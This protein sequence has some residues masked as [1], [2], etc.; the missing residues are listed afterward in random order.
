MGYSPRDLIELDMT[1]QLLTHS[2]KLPGLLLPEHL[3]VFI[4]KL[5]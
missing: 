1:E 4:P 5:I 3:L 2:L